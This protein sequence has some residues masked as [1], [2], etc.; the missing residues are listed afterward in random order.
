MSETTGSGLSQTSQWDSESDD[1]LTVLDDI[2]TEASESP[3]TSY[4]PQGRL[5]P[6]YTQ[7]VPMLPAQMAPFLTMVTALPA[8]MSK[9]PSQSSQ[10]GKQQASSS[11]APRTLERLHASSQKRT[12]LI[13]KRLPSACTR[14]VLQSMLNLAGFAGSYDFLY[15]PVN[16]KT[17]Q[18][19]HYCLINFVS[20]A[21]AERAL[22]MLQSRNFYWPDGA[23]AGDEIE[24]DWCEKTQGLA[25]H[26]D[27]YRNS[28]VMHRTVPD[29]FKP[30]L[31]QNGVRVPFP[32][33]TTA[34]VPP[35]GRKRAA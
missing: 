18:L 26:I 6:G 5:Y 1:E 29:E 15:L 8:P 3:R 30:I 9:Q 32:F 12:T 24:A 28:P 10:E 19:F 13:M 22:A 7:S 14:E 34:I 21:E 31:L 2:A 25:T 16:F 23:P 35:Q 20:H 4:R 27:Q 17:W 33:P 11:T